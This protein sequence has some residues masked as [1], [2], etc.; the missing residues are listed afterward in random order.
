MVSR[1]SIGLWLDSSC[2]TLQLPFVLA[3][4]KQAL[5]QATPEI[6]NSDQGS[7]FTSS[8][9]RK[10]LR[11]ANVRI[12]RDGKGR[13]LDNIFVERL[14]RSV[15]YEEVYPNAYVSPREAR[16][17]LSRYLAFYNHERPHQ[18]LGYRTPAEVYLHTNVPASS[19]QSTQRHSMAPET[20]GA[21]EGS[22][23]KSS[24]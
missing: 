16:A 21:T 23:G 3:A 20:S 11:A 17:G 6:C 2:V 7:H 13:A 5:A 15:K 14:W 24:R 1:A 19:T 4:V 9:Y 22:E 10:L 18:A 8:Q 12:S